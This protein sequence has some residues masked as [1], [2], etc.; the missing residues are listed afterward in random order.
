MWKVSFGIPGVAAVGGG[1]GV[2]LTKNVANAS[3]PGQKEPELAG[4]LKIF[5]LE[6]NLS[7]YYYIKK[8]KIINS[9]EI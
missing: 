5:T 4:P 1:V 9:S 3:P 8:K 2:A 7:L 6:T